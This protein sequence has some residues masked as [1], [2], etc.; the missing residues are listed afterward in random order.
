MRIVLR[1]T[2]PPAVMRVRVGFLKMGSRQS[3][4]TA[5][6][7]TNVIPLE[8]SSL[9]FSGNSPAWVSGR[10]SS[11]CCGTSQSDREMCTKKRSSL[12]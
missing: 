1:T 3:A 2:R 7:S 5:W 12:T 10:R 9:N 4:A 8:V 6:E 11:R